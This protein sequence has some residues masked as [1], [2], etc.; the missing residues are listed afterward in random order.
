MCFIIASSALVAMVSLD[1]RKNMLVT[2]MTY[3]GYFFV[4][5]VY[6]DNFSQ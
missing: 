6:S 2:F 3:Q 1:L 5:N 4:S